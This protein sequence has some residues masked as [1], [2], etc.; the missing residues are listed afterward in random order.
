M[1]RL[2]RNWTRSLRSKGGNHGDIEGDADERD[3]DEVDEYVYYV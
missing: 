1:M 2:T 3:A